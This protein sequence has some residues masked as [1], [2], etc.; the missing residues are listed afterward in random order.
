MR[1]QFNSP[2][3]SRRTITRAMRSPRRAMSE[4]SSR[5]PFASVKRSTSPAANTYV[6]RPGDTLSGIAAAKVKDR[7]AVD[8]VKRYAKA[9]VA[10]LCAGL[11]YLAGVLSPEAGI[12]DVTFV[13]WIWFSL[14]VLGAATGVTV[15]PNKQRRS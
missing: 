15:V 7:A 1:I 2:S 10:A 13:Q 5:T 14:I 12:A 8:V 6:V 11:G 4:A 3:M 9:L